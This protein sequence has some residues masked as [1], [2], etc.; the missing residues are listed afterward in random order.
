M[1]IVRTRT[2]TPRYILRFPFYVLPLFVPTRTYSKSVEEP[3]EIV[4]AMTELEAVTSSG[5]RDVKSRA[6]SQVLHLRA[7]EHEKLLEVSKGMA[8]KPLPDAS[9]D[10][11]RQ[12]LRHIQ[13]SYVV[14]AQV[15]L[16]L[17]VRMALKR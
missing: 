15:Y 3:H 17:V 2:Q 10:S 12:S 14:C 16:R 4:D 5:L 11:E 13:D 7:V 9:D 1:K 8:A 6:A